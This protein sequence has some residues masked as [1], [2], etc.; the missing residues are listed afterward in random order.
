MQAV[1]LAGA[2]TQRGV[3]A[4][5]SVA[6]RAAPDGVKKFFRRKRLGKIIHRAGLDGFD[7][8]FGRGVGG[9]HQRRQIWPPGA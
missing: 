8:E 1:I 4:K 6:F 2:G 5:Q 9:D 7:S 3:F